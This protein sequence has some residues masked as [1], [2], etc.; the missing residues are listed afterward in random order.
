MKTNEIDTLIQTT[1]VMCLSIIFSTDPVNRKKN[2]ETLKKSIQKAKALLK[3]KS[4]DSSIKK[5]ITNLLS[6]II[7]QIP[8]NHAPGLGIFISPAQSTVVTFPF[9]VK[10]TVAIG[11]TFEHRDLLYLKQ[12]TTPYWI[13]NL[14]KKGVHVYKA[15]MNEPEEIKDE[16]FPIPYEDLYE[17]EHAAQAS[18]NSSLKGF[19]K[20][21]N[22]I[23]ELRLQGTFRSA[24]ENLKKY[25]ANDSRLLLAGT[26]R[27][28][29]L[30]SNSTALDNYIAGKV[31]GSYN[32]TNLNSLSQ[33]AWDVYVQ[34]CKEK[35]A[36]QIKN[37]EERKTSRV[38][39]GLKLAW[40]AAMEGRGMTLMVEKDLHHR[41]YR[42]QE[43]SKLLLQPPRKPYTVIPDAV[44]NLIEVVRAKNGKIVFTENNQL[45]DFDHLALVLRY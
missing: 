10:S 33:R 26:Q 42:K 27:M 44:E 17:Y 37:L 18:G 40:A 30:F 35:L 29:S 38:A 23:S 45:K 36:E 32:H 28:I 24:E 13:L 4:A 39:E 25:L 9:T 21:K 2:Y 5:T 15:V 1:D 7:T 8:D 11:S 3:N 43:A 34:M 31:T 41:A 22:Q 16:H 6:T 19:E 20:E 12:Y 14:T